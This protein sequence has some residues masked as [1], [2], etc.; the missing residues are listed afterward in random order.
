MNAWPRTGVPS[1]IVSAI[2]Q[3]AVAATDS[4]PQAPELAAD[5]ARVKSAQSIGVRAGNWLSLKHAQA[6]LN[7][8]DITTTQGAARP[9]HHRAVLL[10]G[11]LRQSTMA[12][13]AD[14]RRSGGFTPEATAA[15]RHANAPELSV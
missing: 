13:L 9:R 6:L 3:L 11:V 14:G 1:P 8:P 2:R 15:A 12:A 4:G 10:G 5:V 7:A